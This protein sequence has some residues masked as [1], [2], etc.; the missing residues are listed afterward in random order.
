MAQD[1]QPVAAASP[2]TTALVPQVA[3]RPATMAAAQSYTVQL[4]QFEGPFDLL[5]FF[6]QRDELNIHDIPISRLTSDFLAYLHQ[7]EVRQIEVASEFMV[8]AA[9][10][11]KI[12]AALLLPRP[13]GPDGAAEDPRNELVDRLLEY[14][15]YKQAADALEPLEA[16]RLQR[17]TR[18]YAT[19][20]QALAATSTPA[21]PGDE[22]VGLTVYN[23]FK[24]YERLVQRARLNHQTPRHV[25][26]RY[27]YTLDQVKAD[28]LDLANG[29]NK[30]EFTQLAILRPDKIYIVF[31]FLAVLELLNQRKI[32]VVVGEGANQFWLLPVLAQEAEIPDSI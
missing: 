26:Q 9:Q 31:A 27:P 7:M 19:A 24:T 11:M 17:Q 4:P 5:L 29:W 28:L 2:E 8:V 3:A 12:K 16:A 10:L 20:E 15:R 23:L 22:L 6:I 30:L 32:R 18:G 25:I 14:K 21:E 1:Q 13:K